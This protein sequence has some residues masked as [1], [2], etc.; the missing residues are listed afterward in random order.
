[1]S[2]LRLFSLLSLCTLWKWCALYP[3]QGKEHLSEAGEVGVSRQTTKVLQWLGTDSQQPEWG[4]HCYASSARVCED[5]LAG[6]GLALL[7][8]G[9]LLS[10]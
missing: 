4:S 7:P 10:Q 3:G 6:M 5:V 1:M 8:S 9:Y 2:S